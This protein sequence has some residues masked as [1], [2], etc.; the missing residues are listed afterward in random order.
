MLFQCIRKNRTRTCFELL[1]DAFVHVG[2]K[3]TE[4]VGAGRRVGGKRTIFMKHCQVNAMQHLL[5]Q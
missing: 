1:M 2:V 3:V 5:M 4:E